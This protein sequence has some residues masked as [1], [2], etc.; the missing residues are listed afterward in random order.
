M[1]AEEQPL[2][3]VGRPGLRVRGGGGEKEG[4]I[5]GCP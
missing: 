2:E 5:E 4:R 3:A 1:E